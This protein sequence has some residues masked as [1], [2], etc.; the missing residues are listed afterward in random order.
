M[1]RASK[2][3]RERS[4]AVRH[5][6]IG[7]PWLSTEST[8]DR[9]LADPPLALLLR[10]SKGGAVRLKF[11]LAVLWQ[12]G[13]GD[14]RHSVNWPARAWAAL[15]DLPDPERRGD[16]R[17]RDAI[18]ALEHAGLITANRK[19]GRPTQLVLRRDDASGSP[20]VHPGEA[21][22]A[23]KDKGAFDPGELYVQLPPGFWTRGWAIVLSAPGVAMLLVMLMLTKNAAKKGIW[24]NPAQARLRFGLSE[25][26]WTRGVA[27]LRFHGLVEIRK[28]P[29]SEDFGWRR[30]RNTYTVNF[31]RLDEHPLEPA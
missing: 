25:D 18:R 22:H 9:A 16:R 8:S 27:E 14:Q 19:L 5:T 4:T 3:A 11:Y 20:Y 24:I 1:K 15:L 23:K 21:A 31:S 26:T 6:F 13:G 28:K 12:A 29:V 30:V 17:I 10:A 7:Q 2:R